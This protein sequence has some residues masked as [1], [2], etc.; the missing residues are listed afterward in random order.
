MQVT[1]NL[2]NNIYRTHKKNLKLNKTALR[3][4]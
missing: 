2:Q 3:I 1:L 4:Q